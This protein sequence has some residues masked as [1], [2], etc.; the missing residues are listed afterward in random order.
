MLVEAIRQRRHVAAV[1]GHDPSDAHEL[2][3]RITDARHN[4][5]SGD[6]V[7]LRGDPSELPSLLA[8]QAEGLLRRRLRAAGDVAVHPAGS[9]D[10]IAVSLPAALLLG[11]RQRVS[12]RWRQPFS[13]H[14]LLNASAVVLRPGGFLATVTGGPQKRSP[15]RDLGGE[16][17]SLCAELG[18]AYWQHIV[19]LLVPV[20][21][22][23]LKPQQHRDRRDAEAAPAHVVHADVHIFRKPAGTSEAARQ[24]NADPE[25]RYAA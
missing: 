13:A 5:A 9:A 25:A 17:V 15:T 12:K 14:D 22:G 8:R 21:D 19:A 6:A 1:I 16:T 24:R 2:E 11:R 4:G 3:Q 10:L 23:Q 20:D 7:L 18:L